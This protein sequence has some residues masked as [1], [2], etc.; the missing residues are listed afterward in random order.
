M[1]TLWQDV[2]FGARMLAKNPGFT[3]VAVLTLSLGIG[4]NSSM[5]SLVDAALLRSLPVQRPEELVL[6]ATRTTEGGLHTDFSYPLFS[7][8]READQDMLEIF[9]Y[10][11]SAFGASVGERTERVRG[12]FVSANYFSA[13]GV[14]PLFGSAFTPHDEKP[15]APAAVVIGHSLWQRFF[16]SDASVLGKILKVDGLPFSVVGVAPQNFRGVIRGQP[17]ELWITL[18]H[19]ATLTNRPQLLSQRTTS[20]M[21]LGGRLKPGVPVAQAQAAMTARLPEG[22]EVARGPGAWDVVLTPAPAGDMVLLET[23][24]RPLQLLFGAVVLILLIACANVANLLLAR[25][26][27]RQKEIGIRIALGAT[28]ARLVRQLLTESVLLAAAGGS[29]GLVFALWATDL[30]EV[31][32]TSVGIS[33]EASLNARVLGFAMAVSMATAILFGMVPAIRASRADLV[34]VLKGAAG[35]DKSGRRI[36][37]PL[38]HLLVV[39]QVAL[40]VVLLVG[41]GLFLRSLVKLQAVDTGFRG[42]QVLAMSLDLRLQGYDEAR[43]KN[44]YQQ[45]L[46]QSGSLP[47]VQSASLASALPVTAGGS[48]LQ[49]P[50]NLTRPPVNESIS[51]DIVTVTPRFFETVGLPLVRGRDFR[52]LDTEKSARV[53]IVNETMAEKFWPGRDPVGESFFDG[54][55]TFAVVGVARNTKYRSLRESP[56]MTMYIPLAQDYSRSMNLLVRTAGAPY[57]L[58]P[59]VRQ[60]VRALDAAFPVFNIRTMPE[61]VGRSIFVERMQAVLLVVFGLLAMALASLGMYGVMAYTVAQ[62]TREVGIR[63]ALGAQKRDVLGLVVR[64]GLQLVILGTAVGVAGALAL[65]QVLRSLL[66]EISAT[67]PWTFSGAALLLVTVA[68]LACYVPARRAAR[69]DPMVALRY[70]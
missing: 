50:G 12:E 53:T 23:A 42:D 5:F 20:W 29:L 62:R 22:F 68:L 41:A 34:P 3:A 66:Y 60:Q 63:M 25:A 65:T 8:L 47:G 61:H 4:V 7:A 54:G 64:Q 2:K 38:R 58:L 40:S 14:R 11:D 35:P 21:T 6:V 44:F 32:R 27:V 31:V 16:A 19:Y 28:R 48:R 15:G 49:R 39:L 59:A 26:Q 52:T 10:S 30:T 17:S 13:L 46:E 56:R 55:D 70:E 37:P 33:V 67:D 43:G 69:V 9:A 57:D 24:E 1:E 36:L 51:I 18:P 45:L